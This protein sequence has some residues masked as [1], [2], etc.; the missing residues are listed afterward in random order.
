VLSQVPQSAQLGTA[1]GVAALC[2]CVKSVYLVYS[3]GRAQSSVRRKHDWP[4]RLTG[5]VTAIAFIVLER[6]S[7]RSS[8]MKEPVERKTHPVLSHSSEY[9]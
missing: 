2:N 9:F 7:Q 6:C 5:T 8:S 3:L 4:N 1:T